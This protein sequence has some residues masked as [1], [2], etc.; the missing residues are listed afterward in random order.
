EARDLTQSFFVSLL[1]RDDLRGVSPE[2]GRFR[3][4]L[5]ASMKH[6]LINEWHKARA[7]KRGGGRQPLSLDFAAAES[8]LRLEAV[9]HQTPQCVFEREWAVTLLERVRAQL[10]AEYSTGRRGNHF[11]HLQRYL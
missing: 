4:F 6:F 5:L 2:K 11:E 1:E 9:D 8:R 7:L 10:E 3:S